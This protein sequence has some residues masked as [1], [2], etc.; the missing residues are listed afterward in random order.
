MKFHKTLVTRYNL[1]SYKVSHQFKSYYGFR[2][3]P[4]LWTSH[5]VAMY[6]DIGNRYIKPLVQRK[7][8]EIILHVDTND[9][10][11]HSAEEVADHIIQLTDDIKNNG[12]RRTVSS[13]VVRADLE[14]LKFAVT[15]VNNVLRDSLLEDVNFVNILI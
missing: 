7:P 15:D 3:Y 12:I 11:I 10:D 4:P 6:D 5:I 13:S 8:T 14:L 2:M 1:P 9:A